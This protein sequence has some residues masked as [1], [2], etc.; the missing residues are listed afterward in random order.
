MDIF[1]ARLGEMGERFST[2]LLRDKESIS[3]GG[4]IILLADR[5][6][7]GGG[8]VPPIRLLYF[9]PVVAEFNLD[10]TIFQIF[11]LQTRQQCL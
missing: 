4:G 9:W 6:G 5:G 11:L 2:S 7:G 8:L 1:A 3:S 10:P